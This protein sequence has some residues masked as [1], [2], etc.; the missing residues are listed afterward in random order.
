M[1]ILFITGRFSEEGDF[2]AFD[3]FDTKCLCFGNVSFSVGF[4]LDTKN[5]WMVKL[6]MQIPYGSRLISEGNRFEALLPHVHDR[7]V[8]GIFERL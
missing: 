5:I 4:F 3:E 8:R 2:I 1:N 7:T 6:T